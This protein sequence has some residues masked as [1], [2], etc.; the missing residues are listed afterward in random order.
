MFVNMYLLQPMLYLLSYMEK[1]T[2]NLIIDNLI[3][4]G[5]KCLIEVK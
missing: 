3:Y 5:L 2:I 4:V 1:L